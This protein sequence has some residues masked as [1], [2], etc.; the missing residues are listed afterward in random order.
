MLERELGAE[1]VYPNDADLA[2]LPHGWYPTTTE[3][4]ERSAAIDRRVVI[5][6]Y[7]ASLAGALSGEPRQVVTVLREPVARTVSM[8]LHRRRTLGSHEPL[9]ALLDDER[10]VEAQLR[11]YQTKVLGMGLGEVNLPF[12]TDDRTFVD[13]RD[14]L[15]SMHC[16]GVAERFGAFCAAFDARYGTRLA[17]EVRR[18]NAAPGAGAHIPRRLRN[19]ILPLVERDLELH[20]LAVAAAAR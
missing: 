8:L 10:F 5:G 6:H 14:A 9:E 11:D 1:E 16:V 3:I 12:P 15:H 2:E 20:R 17:A 13:A 7:P 18:D 4:V 19:R